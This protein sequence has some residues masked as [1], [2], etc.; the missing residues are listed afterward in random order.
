MTIA[1]KTKP[2][3]K[4]QTL[5]EARVEEGLKPFEF[6]RRPEIDAKIDAYLKAHPTFAA[7]IEITDKSYFSRYYVLRIVERDEQSEAQ[8][9]NLKNLI[10]LPENQ[11]EKTRLMQGVSWIVDPKKREEVFLKDVRT[12][13]RQGRLTVPRMSH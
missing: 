9:T 8:T 1:L 11:E 4:G 2:Q 3:D 5:N 7:R 6:R 13:H 10:D 12:S